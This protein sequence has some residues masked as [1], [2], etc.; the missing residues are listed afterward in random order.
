MPHTFDLNPLFAAYLLKEFP[1][2]RAADITFRDE[3]VKRLRRAQLG[4]AAWE[5]RAFARLYSLLSVLLAYEHIL[6]HTNAL[7]THSG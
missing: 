6:K 4:A 2:A 1:L 7:Q 3:S 5:P